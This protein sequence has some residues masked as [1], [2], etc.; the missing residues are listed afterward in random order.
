MCGVSIWLDGVL[1]DA[2]LIKGLAKGDNYPVVWK[3]L[4]DN[5]LN[6]VVGEVD[7]LAI[8]FPMIYPQKKN[9]KG[10]PNDI[11]MLSAVV[12][13]IVRAFDTKTTLYKPF[14]WKRQIPDEI[15]VKR[16]ESRLTPSEREKI[17]V[18]AKSYIHNTFD[19]VGIGLH[20]LKKTLY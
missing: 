11:V 5:I 2:R 10:D 8:E 14:E 19:S 17:T 6:H 12:G 3:T 20:H 15:V 1:Q 16:I 9:Q 13:N 18:S 4:V 7:E